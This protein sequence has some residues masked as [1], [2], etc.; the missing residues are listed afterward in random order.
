LRWR[1]PD[2]QE[3]IRR[4]I[5]DY[6]KILASLISPSDADMLEQFRRDLCTNAEMMD[7]NTILH[8]LIRLTTWHDRHAVKSALGGCMLLLSMA[9]MIRR[10]MEEVLGRQFPEEDEAGFTQS[11]PEAR[12]ILFGANRVLDAPQTALREF[13]DIVKPLMRGFSLKSHDGLRDK[14]NP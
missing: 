7:D 13:L 11:M 4:K 14:S 2:T 9:E 8:V 1:F 10:T 12:K 3:V 5:E 6:R